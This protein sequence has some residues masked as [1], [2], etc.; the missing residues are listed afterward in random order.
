MIK[1]FRKIRQNLIMEN[2][3]SKY[4]KYAIGEI[5]L[6]VI[7]IL[8]A[9]QINNW[10]EGQKSKTYEN[11]ILKE[12]RASLTKDLEHTKTNLL[13]GL[14]RKEEATASILKT[15]AYNI[16]DHDSITIR[17]DLNHIGITLSF[18]HD[19]G[20]YESL[21]ANGLEK[22]SNDSLRSA[23]VRAYEVDL[24]LRKEQSEQYN[25]E[26]KLIREP[27]REDLMTFSLVIQNKDT[28]FVGKSAKFKE[29]KDHPSLLKY[30]DLDERVARSYRNW[31]ESDTVLYTN[32]IEFI[33]IELEND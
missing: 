26:N 10:N 8:I 21:K 9:L 14:L 23:L 29:F 11:K 30:I 12:I 13:P 15:V 33:N 32:L 27:L 24:P 3:T 28:I 1:F 7:G 4:F 31:I 20:P 16:A 22:I 19:R 5:L 2:K 6:V 25:A 18:I 17:R